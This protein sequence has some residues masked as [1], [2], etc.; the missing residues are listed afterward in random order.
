MLR[1]LLG[2]IATVG[3]ATTILVGCSGGGDDGLSQKDKDKST[4]TAQ[5]VKKSGGK[6]DSVSQEDKDYLIKEIGYGSEYNAKMFFMAQSGQ[7]RRKSSGSNAPPP[8]GPPGQK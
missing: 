6:W 7:L 5:I 3:L 2:L 8:G 1:K 4:R